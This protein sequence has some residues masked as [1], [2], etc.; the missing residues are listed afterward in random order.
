MAR[1]FT[2]RK[3]L[4][5]DGNTAIYEVADGRQ[6]FLVFFQKNEDGWKLISFL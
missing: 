6:K 3:Y 1:I 4:R 2:T 5:T